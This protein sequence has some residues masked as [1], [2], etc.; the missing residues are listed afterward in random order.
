MKLR[1]G[2]KV[3]MKLRDGQKVYEAEGR[4]AGLLNWDGMGDMIARVVF[5]HFPMT[6]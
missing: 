5:L 4:T 1:D 3:D 6:L 2:Q